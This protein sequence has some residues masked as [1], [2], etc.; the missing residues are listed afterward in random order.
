MPIV[1]TNSGAGT[2]SVPTAS[3]PG[4]NLANSVAKAPLVFCMDSPGFGGAELDLLRLVDGTGSPDAVVAGSKMAKEVRQA[5]DTRGIPILR[6]R[7][8]SSWRYA[9]PGL[10]SAFSLLRR[11]PKA[12]FLVWAHHCDS[13]RW[14]QVALALTGR[15]FVLAERAVPA[16]LDAFR[17]SRL[18]KP[19]KRFVSKRAFRI[20]LNAETQVPHYRALFS[21]KEMRLSVIR[22]SR[23][24]VPIASAAAEL[25]KRRAELRT[26]LGLPPGPVVL[27]MGRLSPE[28]R[29]ENV[30]RAATSPQLSTRYSL[31]LVGDGP[32]MPHLRKLTEHLAPG[33]VIFA[34]FQHDPVPWLAAADVFVLASPSEGLPG[35]LIE[36]MAAHLPCIATDIP[37]NRDLIRHE[38]T[39]LLVPV[40]SPAEL[41][42]A[43]T[44]MLSEHDL[45]EDLARAGQELV[46]AHHNEQRE[47]D[48]WREIL[49]E[50][51]R[52]R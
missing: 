45:A 32:D 13:H 11:L 22:N 36:A 26:Q 49:D 5:L 3:K 46:F 39:G 1:E 17:K 47:F 34:G 31:V 52:A 19:I 41:A 10:I 48:Q 4:M 30:V 12:R 8:R 16:D 29:F 15:Q 28:K 33:R 51:A 9:V 43:I 7:S 42:S 35:A 21:L 23:A 2:K 14:L 37:G 6:L 24:V 40:D 50:L 44:R 27:S 20:V 18:S 25:R 38:I